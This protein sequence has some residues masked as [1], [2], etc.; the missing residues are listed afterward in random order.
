MAD[1]DK[2][3]IEKSEASSFKKNAKVRIYPD[4]LTCRVTCFNKPTYLPSDYIIVKDEQAKANT[5][6]TSDEGVQAT[7]GTESRSDS[8][9]RARDKI[10]EMAIA[11]DWE[12]MVTLTL[13]K[14]KVDRYD[15]VEVNKKVGK[16]LDNKVSRDDI[17]Y[18]VVPELHKD[19]AIH[20]HGFM[21]G[22]KV[23]DSGTFKVPGK[24]KPIK[25][26]TLKKEG[27]CPS[28]EGVRAVYNIPSFP[29]GF[30]TAVKIDKNV[31][32]VAQ[33]ISKYC[34]KEMKKIFGSHYK[35]GGK[36]L[37][38]GLP[39]ILM[40]I[41]F[42]QMY[43]LDEN[44][45]HVDLKDNL[46]SVKYAKTDLLKIANLDKKVFKMYYEGSCAINED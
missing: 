13:D 20:F 24:K 4:S 46:G 27:L 8:T 28:S 1:D 40:D 11:N 30:S 25:A 45:K 38:R 33:Y 39:Y 21:S 5:S 26:S 35:A 9:K 6:A 22:C 16:W 12:Y 18:L 3:R 36:N 37:V 7:F 34:T 23:E 29:Y 41:P 2:F 31:D 10:F 42:V 19:G 15:A 43:E 17:M 14:D 44:C 32:A